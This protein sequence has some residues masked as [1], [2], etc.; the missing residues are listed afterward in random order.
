MRI[1][2]CG[3]WGTIP[4]SSAAKPEVHAAIHPAALPLAYAIITPHSRASQKK[5][6]M[7]AQKQTPE[8][9]L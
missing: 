5:S 4:V 6:Y 1:E 9:K 2:G 3:T 8:V 7:N